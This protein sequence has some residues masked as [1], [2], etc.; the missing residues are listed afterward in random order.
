MIFK[1]FEK[2]RELGILLLRMG[3]GLMFVYHGWPKISGG[4]ETWVKL[5][6]AM[7]FMGLGFAPVFWG[8]MSA[9]TEFFGGILI[10]I[11]L[12]T[13]PVAMMLAFNMVVAV[14][15]KFSTGA[16]MG[17]ASEAI[18]VGIV[19]L[20]LVLIGPGKYSIDAHFHKH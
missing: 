2:Y 10:A 11:G 4:T 13:R 18:E 5:G 7:N 9:A 14:V 6:M 19:F 20:S 17:G 12:L 1:S 8:F 3:I 15:L 16:G